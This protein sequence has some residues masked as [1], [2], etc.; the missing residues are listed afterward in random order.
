MA[1]LTVDAE[2]GAPSCSGD[3]LREVAVQVRLAAKLVGA[4]YAALSASWEYV[5]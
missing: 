4:E 5:P 1:L 3:R 2:R